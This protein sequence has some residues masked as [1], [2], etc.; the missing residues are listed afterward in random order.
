MTP[1]TDEQ[2]T[3]AIQNFGLH[4]IQRMQQELI[5]GLRNGNPDG[6]VALRKLLRQLLQPS[7]GA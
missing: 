5:E 2:I 3:E 1:I 6:Y 4:V 7:S